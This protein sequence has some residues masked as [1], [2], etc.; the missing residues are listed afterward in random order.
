MGGTNSALQVAERICN[1]DSLATACYFVLLK[2]CRYVDTV[3][4]MSQY[5]M[6]NSHVLVPPLMDGG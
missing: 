1:S 4:K 5:E 3:E 2:T 6:L